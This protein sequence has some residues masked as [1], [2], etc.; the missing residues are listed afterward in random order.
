MSTVFTDQ[1]VQAPI[2]LDIVDILCVPSEKDEVVQVED[3]SWG[4]IKSIY[5]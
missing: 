1:F 4:K 2:D 3:G 5:R